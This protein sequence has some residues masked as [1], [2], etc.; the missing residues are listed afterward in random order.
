MLLGISFR[1]TFLQESLQESFLIQ[2]LLDSIF[3]GISSPS[4]RISPLIMSNEPIPYRQIKTTN[5]TLSEYSIL[6]AICR[7]RAKRRTWREERGK[8]EKIL[9]QKQDHGCFLP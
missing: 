8:R 6:A 3:F 4:S 5:P 2:P 9:L 7:K 1:R